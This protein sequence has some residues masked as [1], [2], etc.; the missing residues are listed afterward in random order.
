MLTV[1]EIRRFIDDDAAS[2]RKARAKVGQRYYEGLHDILQCRLFYYNDD[3]NLVEDKYRSNIRI[4]HPFFTEIVD[5]AVQY[6]LSGD[7]EIIKSD[8]PEL[9]NE[10]DVYFNAN[11]NFRAELAEALTGCMAN[12]F[13]YLHAYKDEDDR[14]AFQWSDGMGVVEVRAKDTDAQAEHLIYW[15]ID[16]IEKGSKQIKRIQVWDDKQVSFFV[17]TDE[18]EIVP[19]ESETINPRPHVLYR[20]KKGV[21]T[22][23][24]YGMIPFFRLD[25]NRKQLSDLAPIKALIDDYD[26]MASSL[27]NNL[28]DFDTPVHVVKGFNGDNFDELQQNLKTKKIVGVDS[29][30]GVE[31]HTVD[32]PYQA[33]QAKLELDEKNIYRFGFGLNTSGLKDTSATTNIAIKAAY[34]LLEL[35]CEKLKIKLMQ[36][37]RKI[38]RVVLAEI[39]E[40][41]GTDFQQKDVYFAFEPVIM[42][43][44]AENAQIAQT[45]AA[46]QQMR[47]DTLLNL[48]AHL[49]NET[50]MELIFEQLDLNYEDYKD[51]L[52]KPEEDVAEVQ[53]V[54]DA[55]PTEEPVIDGG[56]TI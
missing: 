23:E 8:L 19:D 31:V 27:S 32:I 45:E 11:E 56:G 28:A 22:Y 2:D 55:I 34:S 14:T 30:G 43:N 47:I 40:R 7:G 41:E 10:L 54:L 6:L 16:R 39:N 38:L 3:G 33:R 25:N 15:Y 48:A 53:G 51:K 29:E 18:G 24:D 1:D 42:S 5:Q 12:G 17:Q 50:L 44:A 9:Q 52:P 20:D 4:P 13:S 49:D 36:F 35:K 46:T 37:L 26:V 21:I